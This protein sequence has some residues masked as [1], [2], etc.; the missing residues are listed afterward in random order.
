MAAGL[1]VK[2]ITAAV[3]KGV[4]SQGRKRRRRVKRR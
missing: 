3:G 2:A 1:G 4:S